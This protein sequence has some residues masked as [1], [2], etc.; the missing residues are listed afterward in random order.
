MHL[1]LNPFDAANNPPEW[2]LWGQDGLT[3]ASGI[4][5]TTAYA[6]YI[7]QSWKDQSYGMPILAIC[8]NI[9]WEFIYGVVYPPAM[10]EQIAFMPWIFIDLVLMYGTVKFGPREWK[11]SPLV[12]RNLTTILI[13]GVIMTL[14][15]HWLFAIQF[16]DVTDASFWSGYFCQVVVSWSAIAQLISRCSTRGHSMTIWAYR[17]LGTCCAT[18]VFQ[19]RVTFYPEFYHYARTPVGN[20]LLFA[21]EIAELAYPFVYA[22]VKKLENQGIHNQVPVKAN[23][24]SH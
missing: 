5:W 24:K 13:I 14:A 21:P 3:I 6:L 7:R 1:P 22:Y 19:W 2:Y 10:A 4:L 20:Y 9:T 11:H 16:K 12:A 23:G 18:S 15:A 8:C 17:F